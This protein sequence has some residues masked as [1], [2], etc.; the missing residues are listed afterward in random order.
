[1]KNFLNRHG[2]QLP[3]FCEQFIIDNM[4]G[5]SNLP[6]IIGISIPVLMIL[7]V[8]GSIY[9]PALLSNA[10]PQYNFLYSIGEG[11]P[12]SYNTEYT[13]E[14]GKL[15]KQE[16]KEGSESVPLRRGH[17]KFF[18]HDVAKN[19]S[20]DVTFEEAQELELDSNIKSPD[21]FEIVHGSG[22][23]GIFPFFF[24]SREDYKT[25]YIKGHN[26]SKKLEVQISRD[27]YDESFRFL[28]WIK[29]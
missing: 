2:I 1:M 22:A 26:I 18:I 25:V 5:K 9:L 28:G 8:T 23:E 14:K 20:R 15:T 17:V 21:S 29:K 4:N 27:S 19:Q 16:I 11:Y 24:S 3:V 7:F 13:V 6:L 10:R 12:F